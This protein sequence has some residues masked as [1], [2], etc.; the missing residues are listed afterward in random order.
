LHDPRGCDKITDA[1]V[2]GLASSCP[3]LTSVNLT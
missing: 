3:N 1:A 2:I